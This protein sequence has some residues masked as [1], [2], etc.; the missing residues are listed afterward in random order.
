MKYA[1]HAALAVLLLSRVSLAQTV[2]GEALFAKTC[3]A[4]YCH[5]SKGVGGGAPRLAA[6]GLS[7]EF[8]RD[9][10]TNGVLG[11]G[12]TAYKDMMNSRELNAVIAYVAALNGATSDAGVRPTRRT[13]T[14]AAEQGRMLFS[15]ATRGFTRCATCHQ[16]NGIGIPVAP[17]LE[18]IPATVEAL[19]GLATPRISTARIG[20]DSMPAMLLARR[21]QEVVFYDL[22]TAPPV[23]RTL[24]PQSVSI[25]DGNSWRHATVLGSYTEPEL[26]AILT[27]LR[28]L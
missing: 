3:S 4:G 1:I 19:K 14:G 22:T 16:A 11:T 6:R 13:F 28:G 15:D 2:S 12:M 8:V 25:S 27:F 23:L 20:G 17:P 10:V 24:P 7:L 9:R 26:A 5:G 18:R 21:A